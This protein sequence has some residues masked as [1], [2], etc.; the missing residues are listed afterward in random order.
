MDI[1]D[2][3]DKLVQLSEKAGATQAEAFVTIVRTSSVYIDDDIPK[4]VS[5]QT[6]LGTGLKFIVGKQIGFTSS[7][8]AS[9]TLQEIVDRAKSIA[10]VSSE[11]PKFLS[12]PDPKKPSGSIDKFYDSNTAEIG[13]EE[14]TDKAMEVVKS[15]KADNVTVPN[16]TLR[17]SSIEF[18]VQNS[19]GVNA[20]SKSTIVF[21]FFTAKS[22]ISG[23]VGEGVQRCWSR[24]IDA[25]DFAG[26]GEKLRSQALVGLEA[27]AFKDKWNDVVAVL[28]PSEG[29]EILGTLVGFAASAEH[30][31]NGSSPWAD[32][33][34]ERVAHDALTISD[35]GRSERGLLSAI[36]DDEGTPT[37]NTTLIENG[38]LQSYFFDSYNALQRDMTSTGNGLR[39]NDRETNG[40]FAIPA[41]C[42]GTTM[43]V[44]SGSKS[45]DDVI[46]EID[47]GIYIEHFAWPIVDP[48]SGAFS[49][50]IRNARLIEKGELT[51]QIKYALWVGNLYESIKG[52][53]MIAANPEVHSNRVI[54]AI[55]FPR[56]E[57]IG[58]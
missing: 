19:L 3:A 41:G 46:G 28:A 31:N 30:V 57:I 4:I 29:G 24:N 44:I 15:A 27:E 2:I 11:D 14:L 26:T 51:K 20:G 9:E 55:A 32:N 10:H 7:T 40:R 52:E 13:N 42:R 34:G 54:P 6:E 50:E 38:V 49:N 45:L 8:L 22:E 36:V 17:A 43:E 18:R 58:Q 5:S 39:R 37:Q 1:A 33:L 23:Q 21:G 48:M 25:I 53:L 16:G 56:T 12:L 47:R 35:N